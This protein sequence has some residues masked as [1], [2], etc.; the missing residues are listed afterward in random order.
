MNL[1]TAR[2]FVRDVQ[3]ARD[4]YSAALGLA[5]EADG[6]ENGYCV[7]DAGAV[8]LV[9]EV[10]DGEDEQLIGRFTGLSFGVEDVE[11]KYEELRLKGVTFT[12]TP[13]RQQWGGVLATLVDPSGNQLQI[14]QA[15]AT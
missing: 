8:T 1:D 12:G 15:A 3:Q 9:I 4:F 7:F 10:V 2:V 6:S 5:L 13:E 14:Y 11:S